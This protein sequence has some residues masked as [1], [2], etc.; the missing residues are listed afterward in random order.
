MRQN[1]NNK[2]SRHSPI[3]KLNQDKKCGDIQVG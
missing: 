2:V 1:V 3:G